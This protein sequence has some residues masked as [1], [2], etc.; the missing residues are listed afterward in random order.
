MDK[1]VRKLINEINHSIIGN[2]CI[3]SQLYQLSKTWHWVLKDTMMEH[4]ADL[5]TV[6]WRHIE[7]YIIYNIESSVL[8]LAGTQNTFVIF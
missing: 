3:M 8:M 5:K 2:E 6:L 7:F 4:G 1:K